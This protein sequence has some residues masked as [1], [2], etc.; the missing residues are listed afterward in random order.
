[1]GG[2]LPL[3]SLTQNGLMNMGRSFRS[4]AG[5]L[6]DFGN[7]VNLLHNYV[8]EGEY[9][10]RIVSG[11]INAPD[12]RGMLKHVQRMQKGI[13]TFSQEITQYFYDAIK[14]RTL[15]RRGRGNDSSIDWSDWTE[16]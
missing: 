11:T 13:V 14:S 5:S 7:D 4:Y 2:L 15:V 6:A 16:V 9:M 10:F 12:T 8:D 1:M 3:G